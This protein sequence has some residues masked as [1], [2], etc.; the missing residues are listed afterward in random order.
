MR[1]NKEW[2]LSLLFLRNSNLVIILLEMNLPGNLHFKT[3]EYGNIKYTNNRRSFTIRTTSSDTCIE[4][5]HTN[6]CHHPFWA[7]NYDL[8]ISSLQETCL[9]EIIDAVIVVAH[10]LP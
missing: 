5:R 8:F 4:Q 6:S 1:V 7:I 3:M 2:V 9:G 10:D